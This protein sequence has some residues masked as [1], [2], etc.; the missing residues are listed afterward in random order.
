MT[1]PTSSVIS[2]GRAAHRRPAPGAP[3]GRAAPHVSGLLAILLIG[4]VLAL[5][6]AAAYTCRVLTHPVRKAYAYA[7][8]KNIPSDPSEVAIPG[9][10]A[11]PAFSSWTLATRGLQL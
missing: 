10:A 9:A 8:Y 3:Q 2:S 5:G 4:L 1:F 7:L 6:G 11:A